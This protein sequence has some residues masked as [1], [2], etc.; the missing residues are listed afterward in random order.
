M[1]DD[2]PFELPEITSEDVLRASRV[3][4]LPDDA[5]RGKDG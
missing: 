5:F 2:N 3:L 1:S 4:K